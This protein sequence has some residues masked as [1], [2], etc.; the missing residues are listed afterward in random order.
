MDLTYNSG[1]IYK[2]WIKESKR[3]FESWSVSDL[4]SDKAHHIY[5]YSDVNEDSCLLRCQ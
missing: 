4:F 1:K 2:D 3:V 5:F